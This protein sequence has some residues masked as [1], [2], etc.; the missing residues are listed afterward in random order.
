MSEHYGASREDW[1]RYS[2]T[3]GLTEDLLPVIS[4]PNA[5]IS[6]NS[7]MRGLGKTPSVYNS[8]RHAVGLPKWTDLRPDKDQVRRWAREPDYGIC[9]QTRRLRAIDID[10]P[11]RD[12]A[13]KIA[14]AIAYSLPKRFRANSGKCL[15]AFVYAGVMPKRV[16]PVD[17]GIVELL[18]DGQ[19]FIAEGQHD[20]GVRYQWAGSL[21]GVPELDESE[22]E[23]LWQK[24]VALFATGEPR[25]ARQK[26]QG[27]GAVDLN[28]DDHVAEW[29]NE[30]WE[31][32]DV[33]SDGQLF[34]E[35]PFRRDHTS[36]SGPT[37][38]AYF[39][40]GTGGY[41]QGHFVCLHAHCAGRSDADFRDATGYSAGQFEDLGPGP[42]LER[43]TTDAKLP[44]SFA[45]TDASAGAREAGHLAGGIGADA[46]S[47]LTVAE[48]CGLIDWPRFERDSKGKIEA[49]ADN[50]VKALGR[51]DMIG[52]VLAFD[53]FRAELIWAPA[54]ADPDALQW[55]AFRDSDYVHVRIEL[56]RRGFKPMGKD[57]LREAVHAVALN[58]E[59]DT[60]IEWLSRQR[61]DG[62][63][64]VETFLPTYFGTADTPYTR[65][66]SRYIWTAHA[67]RIMEP[68]VKADM[69][70]VYIGP[71]GLRKSSAFAA[72]CP[73]EDFFAKLDL[74][75]DDDK[76][77]RLMRGKLLGELEELRGLA[78][79]DS[80][81]IKAWVTRQHEEWVPKFKEFST[82]FPRRLLL[83]GSGNNRQFLADDT[84]E[85]R[86]LPFDVSS[87]IDIEAI[88]L[89]RDQL[90]A[91]GAVM[92]A[93]GG[94]DWREA[95][96]LASLEHGQFKISDTWT[97][98][99]VRWLRAER[100]GGSAPMGDPYLLVSDVIAGAVG[101]PVSQQDRGKELRM[102]R[103]LTSLGYSLCQADVDGRMQWV[104][105]RTAEEKRAA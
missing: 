93:M 33:G 102:Q 31:I 83:H 75:S 22:L 19:Q 96:M 27:K 12:K 5:T 45:S 87:R 53:N 51:P 36:D 89:D 3:L 100:V 24:L 34:I 76:L 41:S 43:S 60:A 14:A 64:R 39:A 4:N 18:G 99:T 8:M 57:L 77:A 81:S 78:S 72:M 42:V 30:N 103:V 70:P 61:W 67:G 94:V 71:Q 44:S 32:Y 55:R 13:D 38:T 92:F 1:L 49:T 46:G 90:W 59:M 50:L 48:K 23:E 98:P 20:S 95:E 69:V 25:I 105:A 63:C 15:F 9:I 35:C 84:G 68:G 79:R 62:V 17:G 58:G 37:S 47:A 11:D 10:V 56:E 97:A 66:V 28:V 74:G 82:R 85:R 40:A 80:E 16:I 29:L 21:E 65:A 73:A 2:E 54:D 104:F 52:R 88:T 7:K 26:R 6:P 101:V 86:W 91:E